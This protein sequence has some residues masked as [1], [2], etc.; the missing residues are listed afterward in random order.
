MR[1][2]D[3]SFPPFLSRSIQIKDFWVLT[4]IGGVN[5]LPGNI[6]QHSPG[7]KNT[8]NHNSASCS[9]FH[10]TK[11]GSLTFKLYAY[12]S[13]LTFLVLVSG[14]MLEI[15]DRFRMTSS[16]SGSEQSPLRVKSPV[17]PVPDW[18]ALI[19]PGL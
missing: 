12:Y 5:I 14:E 11:R 17:T 6:L 2:H 19:S 9:R 13:S 4:T 10:E 8:E 18:S 15:A 3:V 7:L 16:N 1:H